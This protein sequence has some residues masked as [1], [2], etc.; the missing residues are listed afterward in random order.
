MKIATLKLKDIEWEQTQSL[1]SLKNKIKALHFQKERLKK[2]KEIALSV[3]SDYQSLLEGEKQKF[4]TGESSLFLVNTRESKLIEAM[5]KSISL[6]IAQ[7][8]AEITYYYA[9][10]FDSLIQG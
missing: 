5:L 3:V 4:E 1:L 6:D 2:Q 8:K 7:K 9:V 10:N